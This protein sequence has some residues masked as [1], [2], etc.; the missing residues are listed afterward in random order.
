[1][2][3]FN[4][5]DYDMKNLCKRIAWNLDNLY[6]ILPYTDS[7]VRCS[8]FNH[9]IYNEIRKL[10]V[11]ESNFKKDESAV[12]K[13]LDLG[14]DMNRSLRGN[15][16]NRYDY[17]KCNIYSKYIN[18]ILR[19]YDKHKYEC[20]DS[21]S[22][23]ESHCPKY[24]KCYEEFNPESLLSVLSCNDTSL[25]AQVLERVPEEPKFPVEAPERFRSRIQN[26]SG[27]SPDT[28]ARQ[29]RGNGSQ[30]PGIPEITRV[31]GQQIS[32][33]A[34]LR[35]QLNASCSEVD[36]SE[37]N[38]GSRNCRRRQTVSAPYQENLRESIRKEVDNTPTVTQSAH[39]Q[40]T[41][42]EDEKLTTQG[43]ISYELT[44]SPHKT[45]DS[46]TFS[47]YNGGSETYTSGS[48]RFTS[49]SGSFTS[50]IGSYLDGSERYS[51]GYESYPF[52]S[53]SYTEMYEF[54]G[55]EHTTSGGFS[56]HFSSILESLKNNVYTVSIGS[57]AS[58]GFLYFF[59]NYFKVITKFLLQYKKFT[60]MK[61]LLL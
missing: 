11:N 54:E 20:C 43:G 19:I 47:A 16:K 40:Y 3:K 48:G 26:R 7:K 39:L 59:F 58:V 38:L 41:K 23:I 46:G 14:Y 52:E 45:E 37:D 17:N 55:D 6:N 25:G 4:N 34:T 50:G 53:G 27:S 57:V 5:R 44:S 1:M 21:Y 32:T 51:G 29:I 36:D 2:K 35:K 28:E 49:G 8:Y 31:K 12:F 42:K 13:L 56:S 30:N 10:L 61:Y 33:R 15:N 18:Y 60:F 24:F 9:W 22:P